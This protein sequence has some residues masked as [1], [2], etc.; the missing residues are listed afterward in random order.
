[1]TL[2]NKNTT[3]MWEQAQVICD[4]AS[5]HLMMINMRMIIGMMKYI[6]VT[7]WTLNA[8]VVSHHHNQYLTEIPAPTMCSFYQPLLT[9][10]PDVRE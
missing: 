5:L 1:M 7:S 4:G 9:P 3:Q 8:A 6:M 2:V 10:G